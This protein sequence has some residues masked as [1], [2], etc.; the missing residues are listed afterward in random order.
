MCHVL[1]VCDAFWHVSYVL[2]HDVASCIIF[3]HIL[4]SCYCSSSSL[5][6]DSV[7]LPGMYILS[8]GR[9]GLYHTSHD[10]IPLCHLEVGRSCY[11]CP[12]TH[13]NDMMT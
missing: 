10:T 4:Y 11:M 1:C 9:L 7:S 3:Y 2:C 6:D 13:S 8:H 5:V 12:R